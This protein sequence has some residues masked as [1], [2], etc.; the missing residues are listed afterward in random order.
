M[1]MIDIVRKLLG[2]IE[3]VGESNADERRLKNLEA[4]IEVVEN[5]LDDIRSAARSVDCFEHSMAVIG[6]RAKRFLDEIS[7][8]DEPHGTDL[9]PYSLLR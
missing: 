7:G 5:L 9:D 3:P 6:K 1:E 4:T 2:P 8:E